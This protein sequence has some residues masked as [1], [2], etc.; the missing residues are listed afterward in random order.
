[1]PALRG[2]KLFMTEKEVRALFPKFVLKK[3]PF[4]LS[5]E[6]FEAT[7]PKKNIPGNVSGKNVQSIK[8]G[9][10]EGKLVVFVIYYD[11]SIFWGSAEEFVKNITTSFKIPSIAWDPILDGENA[12][13]V[14]CLDFM[15]I[16]SVN[17]G[18]AHLEIS[19]SIEKMIESHNKKKKEFKP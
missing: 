15:M 6:E 7:I 5:G 2:L 13:S 1:M 17:K 10:D 16:A 19:Q 14:T 12:Y 9:F 4:G 8:I 3:S 18:R 11:D